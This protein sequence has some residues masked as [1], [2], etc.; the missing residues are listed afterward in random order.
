MPDH[1]VATVEALLAKINKYTKQEVRITRLLATAGASAS[2]PEPPSPPSPPKAIPLSLTCVTYL[3][4]D[5]FGRVAALASLAP[6]VGLVMLGT[7]VLARRELRALW[8]LGTA[9]GSAGLCV[10]I[11]AHA[12]DPR[13]ATARLEDFGMPSNHSTVTACLA[14]AGLLFFWRDA[15]VRHAAFWKPVAAVAAAAACAAV[16]ASRVWLGEHTREQVYA[17]LAPGVATGCASHAGYAIA[18]PALRPLLDGAMAKYFL[19]HDSGA[20]EP[21][22]K[23]AD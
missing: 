6:L 3:E 18:R 22:S 21:R 16:A 12:R 13:P 4:G 2:A 15:E 11:K 1:S 19:L 9:V 17:G 23:R 5:A 10:V 14:A 8:M 20:Q 7:W